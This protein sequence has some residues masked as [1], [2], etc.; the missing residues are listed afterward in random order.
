MHTTIIDPAIR[1]RY[2][3]LKGGREF[4]YTDIDPFRTAHLVIDMQNAFIEEGALLEVPEARDIV[5]NINAVIG[6]MREAG[7]VNLF[8]R[9]TTTSTDHWPVYFQS[10]QNEEFAKSQVEA[11]QHGSHGHALYPRLDIG[12]NDLVVDKTRFSAFTHGHS[13][14]LNILRAR[15]VDTVFI[16]GTLT[17]VCCE[18]TARDAQQ[19]GFK[20][21]FVADA[22]A[23]LSEAEHNSAVNA[24]AS[25]SA[26]IR[27][28][29]QALA[30]L[31]G[32]GA[33]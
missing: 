11:F 28:T 22:N 15:G 21:I 27:T 6:G 5:D 1:A 25:W 4:A 2:R 17:N 26:D 32:E 19:L 10:F 8:F 7:G 23:A 18:L 20:V 3:V 29:E 24:L 33:E 16:S 12:Q 30:L 9:F 13:D 31:R 14:A